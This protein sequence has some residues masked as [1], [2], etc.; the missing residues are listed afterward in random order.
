MSISEQMEEKKELRQAM[1]FL[2]GYG[3]VS[4]THLQA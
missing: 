2:Q 1:M 3:T 4:Y